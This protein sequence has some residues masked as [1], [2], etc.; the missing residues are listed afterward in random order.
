MGR[1]TT[2]QN[3]F[4]LIIIIAL[5]EEAK[6]FIKQ[7]KLQKWENSRLKVYENSSIL[8]VISGIGSDAIT[9]AVGY[10]AALA[11][12]YRRLFWLN[13]GS[14]GHRNYRIG[15]GPVAEP[16]DE[17]VRQPRR[18]YELGPRAFR[19]RGVAMSLRHAGK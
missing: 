12:S 5:L 11:S 1:Y 7:F 13:L 3:S 10:A 16:Y 18:L 6:P 4:K 15:R 19:A 8:L 9:I 17:R 14:A 2:E